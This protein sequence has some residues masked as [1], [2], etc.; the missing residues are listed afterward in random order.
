MKIVPPEKGRSADA[1]FIA[2]FRDVNM[3]HIEA[4]CDAALAGAKL[5]V[6]S[7][8][9]YFA[10]A[11]GKTLGTSCAIAG[12]IHWVTG[13]RANV[14]GKPA[15]AAL[16]LAARRMNLRTRDLAVIGDDPHLEI[17]MAL[18]GGALAIGVATGVSP[19][20]AFA[21]VPKAKRAGIIAPG[22]GDVLSLLKRA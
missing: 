18:A 15:R 17:P 11:G 13:L 9:P 8:A 12:G 22:I 16:A 20:E 5:Y 14:L 19:V 3:G 6:A 4:A 21:A 10:T 7:I 2:W 1:V